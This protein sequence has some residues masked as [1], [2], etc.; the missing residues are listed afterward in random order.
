MKRHLAIT[1]CLV[2]LIIKPA[3]AQIVEI[4]D[5]NLE[6]AIR[7]ALL[8]PEHLPITKK[9]MMALTDLG[10][11]REERQRHHRA[12]ICYLSRESV[13]TIQSDRR[14]LA[15]DQPHPPQNINA[16]RESNIGSNAPI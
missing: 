15:T 6:N 9:E 10:A 4:P 11:W 5:P 7:E 2:L 14:H 12:A 3:F 13:S 1:L 8:L 16:Y